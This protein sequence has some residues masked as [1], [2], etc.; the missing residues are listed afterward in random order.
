MPS[1]NLR[2]QLGK[3]DSEG[4]PT[5]QIFFDPEERPL[6]YMELDFMTAQGS[7]VAGTWLYLADRQEV[8]ISTV[9]LGFDHGLIYGG[10]CTL[11]ETMIFDLEGGGLDLSQWRHTSFAEAQGGHYNAVLY[12]RYALRTAGRDVVGVR[13]TGPNRLLRPTGAPTHHGH[14]TIP[15]RHAS[16]RRSGR[17]DADRHGTNR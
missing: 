11:W 16:P 2:A 9:F 8:W 17:P 5:I 1:H 3:L 15:A 13:Q 7:S 6:N 14:R 12:A 10:P 4:Y